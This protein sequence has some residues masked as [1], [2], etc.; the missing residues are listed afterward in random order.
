MRFSKLSPGMERVAFILHALVQSEALLMNVCLHTGMKDMTVS[1]NS[2]FLLKR[3][4]EKVCVK[5]FQH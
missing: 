1:E 2:I 3:K 4:G 5:S